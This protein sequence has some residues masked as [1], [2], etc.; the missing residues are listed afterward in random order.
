MTDRVSAILMASGFSRRFGGENKLLVPFRGKA[1]VRHTLDLICS[2]NAASGKFLQDGSFYFNGIY[3]ITADEQVAAAAAGLPVN[4]IRN[5]TPEKGRRE[6]VR[7]GIEASGCQD[8]YFFF[9][10]D[11]PLLDH[12]TINLILAARHRGKIVQP[13]LAAGASLKEES[14]Q[15]S[16]SLFSAVFKEELLALN[17]GEKPNT[18]KTRHTGAVITV[19]ITNPHVLLD[20]DKP[21]D[22]VYT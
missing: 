4:V 11:Q 13:G 21:E 7:L 16:P 6:S 15:Y 19:E 5:K 2:F 1:L 17:E 18:I 8:Y 9:P 22:F 3:L 14:S 20:I 10:C 12:E